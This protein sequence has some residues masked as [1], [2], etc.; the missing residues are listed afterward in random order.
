MAEVWAQLKAA[1][2]NQDPPQIVDANRVDW[3]LDPDIVLPNPSGVTN[4]EPLLINYAGSLQYRPNATTEISNLF[5]ASDYVHTYTDLATMEGANEAARRAT[6]GILDASGSN[7]Q[8]CQLYKFSYPVLIEV[9]RDADYFAFK[10][11][12]PNWF[13]DEGWQKR[14]MSPKA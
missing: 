2:N 4:L 13:D 3:F 5:L 1:L 12:F 8:P 6:N 9:A 11:G 7:T 10:A 14:G